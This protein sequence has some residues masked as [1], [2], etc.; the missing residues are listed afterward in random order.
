M[1]SFSS[2]ANIRAPVVNGDI[3]ALC[4]KKI[5]KSEKQ[6]L[7][8]VT[9]KS[10]KQWHPPLALLSTGMT[11]SDCR[12]TEESGCRNGWNHG[13][14]STGRQGTTTSAC[15]QRQPTLNFKPQDK[16]GGWVG[17][18]TCPVGKQHKDREKS[19]RSTIWRQLG[20]NMPGL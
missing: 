11:A 5:L 9:C 6:N 3:V 12:P 17:E 1:P 4:Q 18:E 2:L 7:E 20:T 16:K 13:V 15:P 10:W 8:E 19:D 14:H